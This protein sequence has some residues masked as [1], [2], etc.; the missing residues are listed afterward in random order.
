[1]SHVVIHN[2]HPDPR[3]SV[4]VDVDELD[5]E[6]RLLPGENIKVPNEAIMFECVFRQQITE[7]G[8]ILSPEANR[9]VNQ[10]T[11]ALIAKSE[12]QFSLPSLC[13]EKKP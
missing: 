13:E 4:A 9:R 2:T 7:N 1:M 5:L 10:T 8:S 3:T 12:R 11:E 6:C